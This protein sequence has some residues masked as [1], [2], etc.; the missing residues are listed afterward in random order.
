MNTDKSPLYKLTLKLKC[1]CLYLSL[2]DDSNATNQGKMSPPYSTLL[3]LT[4]S[5]LPNSIIHINHQ[6]EECATTRSAGT[7]AGA[8][9][10]TSPLPTGARH[11]CVPRPRSLAHMTLFSSGHA[12]PSMSSASITSL[13]SQHLPLTSSMRKGGTPKAM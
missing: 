4:S 5:N 13:Y 2:N 1:E 12:K 9:Y 11:P 8:I 3:C 6:Q 7:T 10:H